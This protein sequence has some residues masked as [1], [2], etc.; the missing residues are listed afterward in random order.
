VAS[1]AL[2]HPKK[3]TPEPARTAPLPRTGLKRSIDRRGDS[4]Y[5][6]PVLLGEP[7]QGAERP[8]ALGEARH[9]DPPNLIQLMLA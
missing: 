3:T 8:S 2:Q 9:G 7:R 4:Y 6:P 5:F 1:L